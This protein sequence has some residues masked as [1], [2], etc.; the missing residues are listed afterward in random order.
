MFSGFQVSAEDDA[1]RVVQ[2]TTESVEKIVH[3]EITAIDTDLDLA[4]IGSR[5]DER[6]DRAAFEFEFQ[7][8]ARE[9][10]P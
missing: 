7:V 3:L 6:A 10:T 4:G 9:I 8:S 5:E 2:T 1:A